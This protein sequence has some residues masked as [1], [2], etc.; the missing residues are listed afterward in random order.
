MNNLMFEK[1]LL[2]IKAGNR[3]DLGRA[4]TLVESSKPEDQLKAVELLSQ[5]PALDHPT[6]RIGVT[7]APGAGKS[8]LIESLGAFL[9]E[10]GKKVA[11]LAIDPSSPF[12][13]GAVLA[14]KTRMKKLSQYQSVY[15]RPS[16]S[17]QNILGGV[18]TQAADVIQLLE[19]A[20]FELIFIETIGVGQNEIA[21]H[22]LTDCVLLVL[23]PGGGDELQALKKGI[24]EMADCILVN[25]ADGD[26]FQPALQTV[27]SY[28]S[29]LQIQ[30]RRTPILSCSAMTG[31]HIPD[32][33]GSI[34][35][36]VDT[37]KKKGIFQKK[38]LDQV[39][40][41]FQE[42][43]FAQLRLKV[44][45][46]SEIMKQMHL[47]LGEI[48]EGR[49]SFHKALKNFIESINIRIHG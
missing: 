13:G 15:I 23:S 6:V 24:I 45:M 27:Q 16:P 47:L 18:T 38:R 21:V 49:V 26:L 37:Q 42:R 30:G 3:R 29:I 11:V 39:Q 10:K 36:F 12:I 7:G 40:V 9:A 44:Q 31:E 46:S 17:G 34:E 20:G 25:K 33:W 5:I 19:Y 22:S 1:I 4:I 2:G 48:Q 28:Q 43:F 14:D 8:T 41:Q 32:V 35:K